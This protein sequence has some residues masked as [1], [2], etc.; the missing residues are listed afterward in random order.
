M[1]NIKLICDTCKQCVKKTLATCE[2]TPIN[3]VGFIALLSMQYARWRCNKGEQL[4]L[5]YLIFLTILRNMN[6][7]IAKLK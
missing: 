3:L 1:F 5:N 7:Q 6:F 2:V 4:T